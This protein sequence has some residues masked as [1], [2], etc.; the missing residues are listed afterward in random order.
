MGLHIIC[1]F[2]YNADMDIEDAKAR[3]EKLREEINYHNIQY[4]SLDNP[5]ISDSEYDSLMRELISLE[6]EFPDLITP[7]SPTQ[8]VG[9]PP[10]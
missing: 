6:E 8:R 10:L 1:D 3:I 9:A 2:V 4:Y 7:D 5:V